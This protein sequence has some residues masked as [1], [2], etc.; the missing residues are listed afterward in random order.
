MRSCSR[1]W[2]AGARG[3]ED[4]PLARASAPEQS[5]LVVMEA[6]G[7]YWQN[8]FAALV[9]KGFAVALLA[10]I[11]SVAKHRRPFST[12]LNPQSALTVRYENA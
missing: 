3:G 1:C 6:T 5:T 11:Y 10:A 12:N 7:H 2:R 9:A 4:L 8:L